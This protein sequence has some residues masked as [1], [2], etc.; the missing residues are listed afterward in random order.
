MID[1]PLER[2]DQI[3]KEKLLFYLSSAVLSQK[4]R[5]NF[6]RPIARKSNSKNL[7]TLH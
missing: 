1:T 6:T 3:A 2:R 4:N 7:I 5:K